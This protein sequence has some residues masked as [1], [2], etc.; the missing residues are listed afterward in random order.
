MK[1]NQETWKFFV[2]VAFS[3]VV[4]TFSLYKLAVTDQQDSYQALYWGGVTGIMAW[5][6]PNPG[7][8]TSSVNSTQNG[9]QS[10]QIQPLPPATAKAN[11][12]PLMQPS[13]NVQSLPHKTA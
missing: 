2:Q 13:V 5:W 6:M 9:S 12:K 1:N 10:D 11:G 7:N 8:G 4:L 3:T